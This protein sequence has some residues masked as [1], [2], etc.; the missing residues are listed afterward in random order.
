MYNAIGFAGTTIILVVYFMV[1]LELL[2]SSRLSYSVL[3][4]VGALMI[5]V[6]LFEHFNLPVLVLEAAW[7]LISL[8]GMF[9][10][11]RRGD[12]TPGHQA[13]Q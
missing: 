7:A 9:R 2:Q 8:Y 13:S 3:N 12:R 1:Q 11:I 5:I 6:S 10:T 4:F